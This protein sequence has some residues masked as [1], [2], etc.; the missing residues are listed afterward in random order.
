M[1][2]IRQESR[3]RLSPYRSTNPRRVLAMVF[4][5]SSNIG[6]SLMSGYLVSHHRRRYCFSAKLI[7]WGSNA[8]SNQKSRCGCVSSL[9]SRSPH[10][11]LRTDPCSFIHD[12]HA[13][14]IFGGNW[15]V[16]DA[17]HRSGSSVPIR[18]ELYL[19]TTDPNPPADSG[20]TALARPA[21]LNAV[22]TF[23]FSGV[24]TRHPPGNTGASSSNGQT[25]IAMVE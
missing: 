24:M 16:T 15:I 18:A 17:V 10:T 7:S 5:S 14:T 21:G 3:V 2:P 23:W 4:G 6:A 20:M 8:G 13:T 9:V 19:D 11:S 25:T 1:Y 12:A 22:I